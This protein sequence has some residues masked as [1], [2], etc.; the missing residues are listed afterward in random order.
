MAQFTKQQISE[1]A[2][3]L[4]RL[5]VKDSQFQEVKGLTK[6]ISFPVLQNGDNALLTADKFGEYT[7]KNIDLTK[8]PVN[9]IPGITNLRSALDK[10]YELAK[11]EKTNDGTALIASSISYTHTIG[12]VTVHDVEAALNTIIGYLFQ[13]QGYIFPNIATTQQIN[14]II[15]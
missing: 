13:L 11:T 3:K 5:G 6:P 15:N 2:D 8:V 4:S 12:D 10:L 1:I 7:A 9:V 14:N